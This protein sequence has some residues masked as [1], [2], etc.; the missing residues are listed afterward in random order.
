MTLTE[1]A[2]M[3]KK[4]VYFL[5]IPFAAVF[6]VWILLGLITSK[7]DLPDKYITA[8]YMCG[9]LTQFDMEALPQKASAA[10]ISIETTSGAIPRLPEV[11]NVFKYTHSS[12][13]LLAL[14]KSQM[15][16]ERFGF[17]TDEYRRISTTEYQWDN[18]ETAQS[19]IIETGNM[20]MY[21]KTDFTN[22]NVD[23]LSETLPSEEQAKI[24]AERYLQGKN[25]LTDDLQDAEKKTY[26]I[27]IT[28]DGEM[29]ES[30]SLAE[31]D[32]IRVD[33]F[34]EKSLITV[35]PQ[36]AGAD[37]LGP[38][39]QEKLEEVEVTEIENE[40]QQI[41]KKVKKYNTDVVND[42]PIFGNISV[43]VGGM[44]EES[45]NN[46]QVFKMDYVHWPIADIACGTYKLLTA[47]EAVRK[48]Q[49]GEATLAH[50]APKDSDRIIPY[51]PRAVSSMIILEVDVV[52]LDQLQRREYLQPIFIIRGEATFDDG[53]KGTFYYY[54]PAIDYESIPEN[55]GQAPQDQ[56]T[57]Q[58]S[59]QNDSLL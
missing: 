59:D 4:S 20:N 6:V 23:T 5:G 40:E 39:V 25:L 50:L 47:Q 54:V 2:E 56:P 32:L 28:A 1:A 35:E 41:K 38:T 3:T 26:L 43:Y 29:R 18:A 57:E 21:L 52:Y 34:R 49:E 30:P 15:Y 33:F 55:A 9:Q 37:E 7:P 11:V 19:L 44:D 24:S 53:R 42:N 12:Q 45:Y 13:S 46:Y 48:V 8:D 16:A 58:P 10:K 17:N 22:P 36:Y 14:E 27:Q 31:A 51:E